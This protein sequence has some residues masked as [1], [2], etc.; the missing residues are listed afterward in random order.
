MK[1]FF[2]WFISFSP[3]KRLFLIV[4]LALIP[5]LAIFLI[6]FNENY[7]LAND[8]AY[9]DARL[10]ADS[11]AQDQEKLIIESRQFLQLL[12]RFPEVREQDITACNELFSQLLKDYPF[13]E[14]IALANSKGDIIASAVH[15]NNTNVSRKTFYEFIL[16]T[17]DFSIGDYLFGYITKIGTI[18]FLYPVFDRNGQIKS[19]L[20][21]PLDLRWLGDHLGRSRLPTGSIIML[22]DRNGTILARYPDGQS[23]LGKKL[24]AHATL[25]V[26]LNKQASGTISGTGIDGIK[27]LYALQPLKNLAGGKVYV[28]VGIPE[29]VAFAELKKATA[30]NMFKLS[31]IVLFFFL[32]LKGSNYFIFNQLNPIISAATQLSQGNLSA[33]TGLSYAGE[34]GH[35]A[36]VFDD[37]AAAVETERKRLY[38]FFD[39]LPGTVW[40]QSPD[41][42]ITYANKIFLQNFNDPI[43]KPC[44]EIF[45][46]NN[47]PCQWCPTV[48]V[49]STAKPYH[50]EQT[51]YDQTMDIYERLLID[52]DGSPLVIKIALDITEKKKMEQE[53]ARLDRLNLVGEM[54]GSIAHE[55]RNPLTTV[56]GFLQMLGRKEEC[57]RLH[58]YFNIMINE[59]DRANSIITE[60]L[61][62]S[63]KTGTDRQTSNLDNII[64]DLQP[65]IMADAHELGMHVTVQLGDTPDVLVNKKEMNQLLLNLVRNGLETMEV[66]KTL[67]IRTFTEDQQVVL[68]VQDQ[69]KGI[70]PAVLDKL[71][72][73]FL[74]TKEHGT[75]LGLAVCYGI[76]NRNEAKIS[77]STS[78][79]GTTFYV[80]FSTLSKGVSHS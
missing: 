28:A 19:I 24:P 37:M 59:L 56:R 33:R 22:L 44:Y 18:H 10:V 15:D 25:W 52:T 77:V 7:Q 23:W 68:E 27:K 71:G 80:I 55:I 74:T 76:A 20:M 21:L 69:G 78:P 43:N 2:K 34:I 40:V 41:C 38:A 9:Q 32:I 54:A 30:F 17:R 8:K 60:Y 67:K 65:L 53:M 5:V 48:N 36:H 14:N 1:P 49:F 75:G 26:I 6:E 50:W 72:T 31:M 62:L 58:D 12:A 66:G 61:S 70:D 73:P 13:Y 39:E 57:L 29:Q 63:R 35:L 51:I 4:L 3:R 42:K 45:Y 47:E 79:T 16:K 11:I 46:G 64:K